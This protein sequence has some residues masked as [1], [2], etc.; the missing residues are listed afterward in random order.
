[1]VIKRKKAAAKRAIR[2]A[3]RKVF[4]APAKKRVGAKLKGK[5]MLGKTYI[6]KK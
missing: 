2:K 4:G 6:K 5:A 3:T 1:M